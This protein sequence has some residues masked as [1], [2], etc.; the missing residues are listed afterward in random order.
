MIKHI[1]V[2]VDH[3]LYPRSSNLEPE[4]IRRI[5]EFV[6]D[7]LH[8]SVEEAAELRRNRDTTQYNSTLELLQKK[9]K[10]KDELAYFKAIH[11]TNFT[12]FFPKNPFLK[13]MFSKINIPCSIFT[14]SWSVHAENVINYLEIGKFFNK[15]YD[16]RFCDYIG[17]PDPYSMK[18]VLADLR[19]APEEVMIIDDAPRTIL[20]F[21]EMGGKEILVDEYQTHNSENFPAPV[22]RKIDDLT[23]FKELFKL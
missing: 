8:I 19:L 2:D 5:N 17:K 21:M 11:P 22:I 16:L 9:Y 18:K 12:D 4:M 6:S 20:T 3:T 1:L 14:N 13:E 10:F 7:Y 15:I 23:K